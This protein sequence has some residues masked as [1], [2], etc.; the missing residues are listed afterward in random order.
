M[1]LAS[2]S[3]AAALR[4]FH[5][6]EAKGVPSSGRRATGTSSEQKGQNRIT[7]KKKIKHFECPM[8]PSAGVHGATPRAQEDHNHIHTHARSEKEA[9]NE[10]KKSVPQSNPGRCRRTGPALSK[11]NDL[12]SHWDIVKMTRLIPIRAQGGRGGG[13]RFE[14]SCLNAPPALRHHHFKRWLLFCFVLLVHLVFGPGEAG[15]G[16]G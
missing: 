13:I 7:K 15:G 6:Q 4:P 12:V 14:F 10:E 9:E 11:S 2:F 8:K 5:L 16:F 3:R 1:S